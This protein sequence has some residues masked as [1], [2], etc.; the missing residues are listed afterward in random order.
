MALSVGL[1]AVTAA[2]GYALSVRRDV[3]AG[4]V[5]A[6]RGQPEAAPWLRSP[7]TF[8]F[9]L[10]RASLIGWASAL[11]VA[12]LLFGWIT[13]PMIDAYQDM[14]AEMLA[15]LG[16]DRNNLIDGYLSVMALT[17]AIL[18]GVYVI[19]GVQAL[20]SEETKGRAEPVLATAAS[21]WAWFGGYLAVL[22][23]GAVALLLIV[24][25]TTAAGTA[26]ATGDAAY[27]WTVTAAHLAHTPAVLVLMAIAA[28]LFGVLPRAIGATW[29][30]LGYAMFVG[31]FGP[32]M[33]LPRW[34][35][36]LSPLEHVG[37]APLDD[38]TWPPILILSGIV[39]VLIVAGL[40]AFRRRDLQTK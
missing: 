15:V 13:Q 6:R 27:L 29:A 7:V 17:E 8:A 21:R 16:G 32:L 12:G 22:G 34:A 37:R 28:L 25:V 14:S 33:D 40:Y 35:I 20:R 3:G 1:A 31:F 38:I 23:V 19:L 9:R 39:A 5:A 18:V 2:A 36:N 10:Q 26:I 11:A 4:L 24:G 30:V